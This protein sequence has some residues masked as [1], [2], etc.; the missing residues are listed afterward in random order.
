[1]HASLGAAVCWRSC[2]LLTAL[3]NRGREAAAWA[4]AAARLW[5]ASGR[6]LSGAP[7]QTVLGDDVA[8][9]GQGVHGHGAGAVISIGARR[10]L[11]VCPLAHVQ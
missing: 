10:L 11:P 4:D 2:Q 9:K 6:A 1:M 8:L 7:L 5:A 3:P